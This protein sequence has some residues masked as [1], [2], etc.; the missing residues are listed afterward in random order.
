MILVISTTSVG[1][2]LR[3]I[4]GRML[5]IGCLCFDL[6]I[7][8][9][10]MFLRRGHLRQVVVDLDV[11]RHRRWLSHWLRLRIP[12]ELRDLE[13]GQLLLPALTM[14]AYGQSKEMS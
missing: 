6:G 9:I 11:G 12:R 4:G 2:G 10:H 7:G 13:S 3:V 1:L 14:L 5:L 8:K